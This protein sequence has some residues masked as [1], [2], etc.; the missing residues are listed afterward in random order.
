M[1]KALFRTSA[2]LFFTSLSSALGADINLIGSISSST[3]IT[4][5]PVTQ[6][7]LISFRIR[8][9]NTGED[10][11]S[12]SISIKPFMIAADQVGAL[13]DDLNGFVLRSLQSPSVT[14]DSDEATEFAYTAKLPLLRRSNY[15]VSAFI[16]NDNQIEETSTVDNLT[17][18]VDAGT[19]SV[20]SAETITNDF[21]LYS[22]FTGDIYPDSGGLQTYLRTIVRGNTSNFPSPTVDSRRLWAR[23]MLADLS[24]KKIHTLP[25]FSYGGNTHENCRTVGDVVDKNWFAISY[26][27][28]RDRHG[29][30]IFVDYYSQA[31]CYADTPPA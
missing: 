28:E 18:L 24:T 2:L 17:D 23:F 30:P 13:D 21:D 14:L 6:N 26:S 11:F 1:R 12:G 10:T 5:D 7:K 8:V 25:Y 22:R 3:T 9:K 27:T 16:N 20:E 15:H 4:T 31:P 19:F 29:T